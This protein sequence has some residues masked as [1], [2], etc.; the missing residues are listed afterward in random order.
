MRYV[1]M[2]TYIFFLNAGECP[3]TSMFFLILNA[4]M[5]QFREEEKARKVAQ[6]QIT[7]EAKAEKKFVN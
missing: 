7:R 3:N 2:Q 5:T 6:K 1:L 4:S